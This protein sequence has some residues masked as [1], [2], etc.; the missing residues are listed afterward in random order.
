MPWTEDLHDSFHQPS[1]CSYSCLHSNHTA[2]L[3]CPLQA[4]VSCLLSHKV[5]RWRPADGGVGSSTAARALFQRGLI[6]LL[7]CC[8]SAEVP[9]ELL[10]AA[11]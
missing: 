2:N 5:C 3:H 7:L 8:Q 10:R 9:F 4:N 1:I 6:L 11:Q